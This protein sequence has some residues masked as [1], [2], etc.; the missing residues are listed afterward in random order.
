M[1]ALAA[2]TG[3][4]FDR[5][6]LQLMTVHHEGAV[7]MAAVERAEGSSPEAI[8][9]AEHIQSHQ[10]AEIQEMADLLAALGG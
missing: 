8:H 1:E 9:L 10:T 7:E 2:A 3:A 5:L 4:D 6:F